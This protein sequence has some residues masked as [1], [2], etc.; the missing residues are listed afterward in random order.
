MNLVPRHKYIENISVGGL[1]TINIHIKMLSGSH[2][3]CF[4]SERIMNSADI[5][6]GDPCFVIPVEYR[7]SV[8]TE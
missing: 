3:K 1:Q 4:G 2:R 8:E 7:K 6:D 5:S